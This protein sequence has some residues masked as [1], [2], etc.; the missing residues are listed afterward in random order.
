MTL[1]IPISIYYLTIGFKVDFS[2]YPFIEI[3]KEGKVLGNFKYN[4][5]VIEL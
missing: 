4:V 1:V 2:Q 3:N 5:G